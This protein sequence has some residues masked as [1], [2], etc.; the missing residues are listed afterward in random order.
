VEEVKRD[1]DGFE[2]VERKRD[3]MSGRSQP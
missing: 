1:K 3:G 2:K